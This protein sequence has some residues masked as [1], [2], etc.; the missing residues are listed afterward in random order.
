[1]SLSPFPNFFRTG[2]SRNRWLPA[3]LA[4]F[5]VP[6]TAPAGEPGASNGIA[7]TD[8][9][10]FRQGMWW[11]PAREGS[12]WDLS[13]IDNFLFAVWYTYDEAGEPTWYTAG[14]EL[15]GQ[16]F[17]ADLLRHTWDHGTGKVKAATVVGT[18]AIEF[19]HP[20]LADVRWRLG[21][22]SGDRRLQPFI[23]AAEPT[24]FDYSGIWYDANEPGYGITVQSQAEATFA[25]VY[26]YDDDGQPTWLSGVGLDGA[27]EFELTR[28]LGN[29]P[30]CNYRE[31]WH[32]T[33][34]SLALQ[35]AAE[36][37]MTIDLARH[38]GAWN[39]PE[40][41]HVM[42]SNPPS[43]RPHPAALSSL[44]SADA[45][46][47][48][49]R[50]AFE[51]SGN[52]AS[53]IICMPP[54]VSP[55]PPAALDSGQVSGTNVQ[56][57][58]V[59]EADV[60]KA[61][62]DSLF[63][64]DHTTYNIPVETVNARE[65]EDEG[66]HYVQTV[67]RFAVAP[68][69]G[70]PAYEGRYEIAFPVQTRPLVQLEGQGLY[71]R[72]NEDGAGQLLYLGSQVEGSCWGV[73]AAS[74]ELRAWDTGPGADFEVDKQLRID[75]EVVAS[76]MIGD[77]LFLLTSY[78]PDFHTVAQA[79]LPPDAVKEQ[80]T[81]EEFQA[82]IQAMD[83][84][85]LLPRITYPDG[86][87]IPL[88]EAEQ[89]LIPPLPGERLSAKLTVLSVFD[90]NDL[91]APPQSLGI[92]GRTDGLYAT[93][94]AV[95]LAG[96]RYHLEFNE[97]GLAKRSNWTDTDLH[98]FA[99][100]E[101]GISYSGSGTVE[102]SVGHDPDRLPF[103]LSEQDGVLRVLTHSNSWQDRWGEW[104]SNRLSVLNTDGGEEKLLGLRAV[105]P[106]EQRPDRIGKPDESVYAVRFLGNRGYVV[107]FRLVDP[108]YALDLSDPDDPYVL[109][110]LEIPGFSDYLHPVDENRLLG[111]GL[112]VMLLE[113]ENGNE[114]TVQRGVQVGLF[115]VS[116]PGD[117][118]LLDRDEIGYRGSSTP[119]QQTH[120]AFTWLPGD[121][122]TQR[123]PRFVLPVAEFGPEDGIP[124]DDPTTWYPWLRT[125]A[126]MYEVAGEGAG[127]WLMRAGRADVG[128]VFT[129]PDDKQGY[130]TWLEPD[131]AR[132]V[133][134][135]DRLLHVF[136]GGLFTT[137]WGGSVFEPADNC[138]L[139][140]VWE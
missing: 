93:P 69:A 103:R 34:G 104:G 11:D 3:L 116:S 85:M 42:M 48:Y 39:R 23:F 12:G 73:G 30:S 117:P 14:A 84:E 112:N 87:S 56:E 50:S 59:D 88:L 107:T 98:R 51:T 113:D 140:L 129:V 4:L 22:T 33:A 45:L 111:V 9:A 90:A 5:L 36:T 122:T 123:A 119:V 128:D 89:I 15:D 10:V 6:M 80:Y 81:D 40:A 135:N 66:V 47:F 62:A 77:R 26:H 136:R 127:S 68:D 55:A 92:L 44:A 134:H 37:H 86:R 13:R 108:L 109:G 32:E 43:G 49:F 8:D 72:E 54:I 18:L 97:S 95:W 16:H 1:M 27:T 65:G 57:A 2:C 75:G 125:G 17:E 71:H 138:E 96:N 102:G 19:I 99:V 41:G 114:F 91:E 63:S 83:G 31:P 60:V 46:K 38:D 110:E 64:I 139:C 130:F 133:I 78:H 61:T 106:N 52:F 132:T 121:E 35:F 124:D 70:N 105:L 120:H 101:S 131:A 67:S 76:R 24:L 25:V 94:E 29:C 53:P 79:A 28:A 115:D 21:E 100:S 74:A 126:V 20:Q 58:G 82:V 118:V 137:P 7:A